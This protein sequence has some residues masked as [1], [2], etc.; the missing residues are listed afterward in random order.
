LYYEKS[1][2]AAR[3]GLRREVFSK[4]SKCLPTNKTGQIKGKKI[5]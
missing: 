2:L 3:K 5:R 1:K 4:R